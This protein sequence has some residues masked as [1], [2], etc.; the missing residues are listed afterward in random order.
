L[1]GFDIFHSGRI[2]KNDATD[3]YRLGWGGVKHPYFYQYYPNR[4]IRTEYETK[5]GRKR[6]ILEKCWRH[7]PTSVAGAVGPL[8]VSQFP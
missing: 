7:L 2:P 3:E 4:N 6:E 8:V 1:K 5:R